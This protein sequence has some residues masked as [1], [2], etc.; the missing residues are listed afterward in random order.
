MCMC[1]QIN[2]REEEALLSRPFS[3]KLF[4]VWVSLVKHWN[5][6]RFCRIKNRRQQGD[7]A[8]QTLGEYLKYEGKS[9]LPST[10]A[11]NYLVHLSNKGD[12]SCQWHTDKSTGFCNGES[13]WQLLYDDQAVDISL[14]FIYSWE[15]NVFKEPILVEQHNWIFFF[16]LLYFFCLLYWSTWTEG[17][18]KKVRFPFQ[19]LYSLVSTVF[20]LYIHKNKILTFPS[21][22]CELLK[23]NIRWMPI[24]V[25][26]D[27][28]EFLS[29]SVTSQMDKLQRRIILMLLIGVNCQFE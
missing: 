14:P 21:S 26:F 11:P 9:D 23:G 15:S 13:Y 1:V 25:I 10:K 19:P 18:Y 12:L 4:G 27:S 7:N 6:W 24:C 3:E 20:I 28:L 29:C 5:F 22:F 8:A 2:P 16:Y 17:L